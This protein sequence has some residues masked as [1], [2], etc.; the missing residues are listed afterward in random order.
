MPSAVRLVQCALEF[1]ARKWV[2]T[3][4]STYKEHCGEESEIRQR[5]LGYLRS[6]LTD[7]SV[8]LD[9]NHP[10]TSVG[11]IQQGISARVLVGWI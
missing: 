3:S 2:D 1:H 4:H 10:P 5:Q 11:G 8:R 6:K 9:L 7:G